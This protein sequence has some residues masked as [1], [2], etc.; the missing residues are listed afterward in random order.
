[1]KITGI[2]LF[3]SVFLV[4]WFSERLSWF[5]WGPWFSSWQYCYTDRDTD[6]VSVLSLSRF[7]LCLF[8]LSVSDS[9]NCAVTRLH[10]NR[11]KDIMETRIAKVIRML[12]PDHSK[13]HRVCSLEWVLSSILHSVHFWGDLVI[14]TQGTCALFVSESQKTQ[15]FRCNLSENTNYTKQLLW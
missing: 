10:N 9:G 13:C 4:S 14:L 3:F 15:L 7:L 6:Q 1:M 11:Y 8:F 12:W 2:F 5:T